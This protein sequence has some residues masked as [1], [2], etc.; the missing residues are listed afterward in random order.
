[1]GDIKLSGKLV[2]SLS[3]G[4]S[5]DFSTTTPSLSRRFPAPLTPST[6]L[7]KLYGW[8]LDSGETEAEWEGSP[9]TSDIYCF[10]GAHCGSATL[11]INQ[12]S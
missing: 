3:T 4:C 1:M 8:N 7:G 5:G 12:L 6:P 11:H 9:D 2:W 10:S